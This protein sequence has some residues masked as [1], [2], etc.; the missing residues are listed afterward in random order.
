[1][2]NFMECHQGCSATLGLKK[3]FDFLSGRFGPR[4]F[5]TGAEGKEARIHVMLLLTQNP[6]FGLLVGG[7]RTFTLYL[8]I[9]SLNSY[10]IFYTL[11]F[12]I[13]FIPP[14]PLTLPEKNENILSVTNYISYMQ[15]NEEINKI[16][17]KSLR[18]LS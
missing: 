4:L 5:S 15:L 16:N 17:I 2:G 1:M 7:A 10:F 14:F 13:F 8:S 9:Y 6:L 18:L 11:I 3:L 12:F